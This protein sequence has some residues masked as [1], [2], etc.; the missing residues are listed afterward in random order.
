MMFGKILLSYLLYVLIG[1]VVIFAFPKKVSTAYQEK[2]KPEDFYGE[3]VS[4]ERAAIV[5]N[6]MEAGLSRLYI[7]ENAKE[8]LY[9]S[10]FSIEKGETPHIFFGALFDAADRGVKV[11]ILLDGVFHGLRG[12]RRSIIYAIANHPNMELK[13]YEKIN[14]LLP[15]TFNNRMHDKYIISDN[16]A[17][18]IGGRNIGDKYFA[19]K[20]YKKEVANDR[21]VVV[22]NLEGYEEEGVVQQMSGY[23]DEIWHHPYSKNVNLL[24]K[25]IFRKWADPAAE[26]L[27][28][29]ATKARE[30]YHEAF[31]KAKNPYETSFPTY[32]MTFVHNPIQRFSKEPWCWYSLLQLAKNAKKSIFI[33]SPYII[34]NKKMT[35]DLVTEK[36]VKR[37]KVTFLTNSLI[38]TP[39]LPAFSGYLNY[40]KKIVDSGVDVLEL[41]SKDSLHSKAFV[42]DDEI[43]AIGSFNLDPRS[44]FLSTESMIVIHSPEI[45]HC[46]GD[47]ILNYTDE[48]LLV[49]KNYQYKSNTKVKELTVHPVKKAV[50]CLFSKF[51]W[52]VDDLL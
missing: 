22:M 30:H 11:N 46:F 8:T 4:K 12:A 3:E 44:A 35:R 10:Y 42:I 20:W 9:V 7:I 26:E 31:A 49:D 19:P 37:K 28:K 2:R 14:P 27:R 52:L 29:K 40:R 23:F 50:F 38:S 24:T 15:W 34:P 1:G 6:P 16:K 32:K 18:I 25:S 41:Q 51:I 43:A 33:Q 39:N 5:D 13:F 36:D 45:V 21:D 48:S 17:A 47:N